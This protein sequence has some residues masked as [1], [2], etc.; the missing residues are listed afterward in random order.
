M[1]GIKGVH[2]I[3]SVQPPLGIWKNNQRAENTPNGYS[4]RITG[5]TPDT[6]WRTDQNNSTRYE[7]TIIINSMLPHS[8]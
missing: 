8:S 4:Y 7:I 5:D 2:Y 1:L 3:G 6:H